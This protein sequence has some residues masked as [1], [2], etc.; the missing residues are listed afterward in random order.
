MGGSRGNSGSGSPTWKITSSY[1]F[2]LNTGTDPPLE[3]QLGPTG[4]IASRGRSGRPSVKYDDDLK[5]IP[6]P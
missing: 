2:P 3:K 5:K 6:Q 4:P 1:R